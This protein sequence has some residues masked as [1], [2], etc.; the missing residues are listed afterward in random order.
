L[1]Q[2]GEFVIIPGRAGVWSWSRSSTKTTT[3][4]PN[5]ISVSGIPVY[6]IVKFRVASV[7]S[8]GKQ[9]AWVESDQIRTSYPNPNPVK[10]LTSRVSAYTA[11]QAQI[12]ANWTKP[13]IVS[14]GGSIGIGRNSLLYFNVNVFRELSSTRTENDGSWVV[15]EKDAQADYEIKFALDLPKAPRTFNCHTISVTAVNIGGCESAEQL[16]LSCVFA[17]PSSSSLFRSSSSSSMLPRPTA[18]AVPTLSLLDC[19]T[20]LVTF[21]T[22]N[23]NVNI[24]NYRLKYWYNTDTTVRTADPIPGGD[25]AATVETTFLPVRPSSDVGAAATICYVVACA[26]NKNNVEVCSTAASINIPPKTPAAPNFTIT[27]KGTKLTGYDITVTPVIAPP[28]SMVSYTLT[29]ET[30]RG[31]T[32]NLTLNSSRQYKN[33]VG[34]ENTTTTFRACATATGINNRLLS[35]PAC[36][37]Q[38]ADFY[39]EKQPPKP[40]PDP[41]AG[42]TKWYKFLGTCTNG[43]PNCTE[44]LVGRSYVSKALCVSENANSCP[45]PARYYTV[46][47][48]SRP[49]RTATSVGELDTAVTVNVHSSITLPALVNINGGV[50]DELLLNSATVIGTISGGV[51]YSFTTNTRSFTLRARDTMGGGIGFNVTVTIG[52]TSGSQLPCP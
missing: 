17:R 22:N 24:D 18:P 44:D 20:I 45:P 49:L 39:V 29:A 1:Y 50:D 3:I 11:T 25:A 2:K 52:D 28:N 40:E 32:R 23:N 21:A 10:N 43:V 48:V 42:G 46:C 41:P 14:E 47:G 36:T 30:E 35:C 34:S 13:N 51:N 37:E 31:G 9:T 15:N 5:S 8:A 38:I 6:T 33:G 19:E 16:T 12:V 27:F 4:A 7:D 26:T